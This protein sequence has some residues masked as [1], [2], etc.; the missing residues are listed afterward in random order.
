MSK[1]LGHECIL[2][3]HAKVK[4]KKRSMNKALLIM[5]VIILLIVKIRRLVAAQRLLGKFFGVTLNR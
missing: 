4:Y 1:P 3:Q 5:T 2:S